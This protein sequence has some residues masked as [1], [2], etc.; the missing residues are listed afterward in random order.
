MSLSDYLDFG[1]R[2]YVPAGADSQPVLYRVRGDE[3]LA[4]FGFKSRTAA[5]DWVGVGPQTPSVFRFYPVPRDGAGDFRV[6]I[7]SLEAFCRNNLLGGYQD[8]WD[9]WT[10]DQRAQFNGTGWPMLAYL[11]MSGN[12]LEGVQEGDFLRFKTLT[13]ASAMQDMRYATHPQFIHRFDIV[14]WHSPSKTTY[15][16]S[17]TPKGFIDWPLVTKEGFAFIPMRYV[18]KT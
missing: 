11:T 14:G 17:N 2:K 1:G 16:T 4:E 13:I 8:K 10:W 6:D 12:L 9:Y 5:L 3:E 15:H 7:S 18:R